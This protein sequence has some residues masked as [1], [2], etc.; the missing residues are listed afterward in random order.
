MNKFEIFF[1]II[2][3]MKSL[4]FFCF[5][6]FFFEFI[7]FIY[8]LIF[9][10]NLIYRWNDMYL[11]YLK[12]SVIGFFYIINYCVYVFWKENVCVV[13]YFFL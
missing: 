7:I 8:E 12:F 1:E 4:K 11:W 3:Y 6:W 5:I 10:F 9:Y 13:L 2:L